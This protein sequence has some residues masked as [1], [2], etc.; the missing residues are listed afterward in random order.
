MIFD[1]VIFGKFEGPKLQKLRGHGVV[2]HC[3]GPD[4]EI[5]LSLKFNHQGAMIYKGLKIGDPI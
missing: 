5:R 4:F 1:F 3:K 2:F